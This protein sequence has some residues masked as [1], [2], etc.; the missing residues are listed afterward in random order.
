MNVFLLSKNLQKMKCISLQRF[1]QL[2]A[3]PFDDVVIVQYNDECVFVCIMLC[4]MRSLVQFGL[5][6]CILWFATFFL[7]FFFIFKRLFS[8][9]SLERIRKRMPR[10]PYILDGMYTEQLKFFC[11]YF[12]MQS[13]YI[14]CFIMHGKHTLVLS[15]CLRIF[16]LCLCLF[17]LVQ[18]IKLK[19]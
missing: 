10:L 2:K 6:M 3:H 13:M 16:F 9:W 19:I 7:L 17:A 12:M 5:V 4:C 1:G 18:G 14:L 15:V 11:C 8:S